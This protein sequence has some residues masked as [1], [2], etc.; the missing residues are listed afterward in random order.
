MC[1]FTLH[2]RVIIT[3]IWFS[4]TGEEKASNTKGEVWYVE[5]SVDNPH[6][7][8]FILF[9]QFSPSFVKKPPH[10]VAGPSDF[11]IVFI[12]SFTVL[13]NQVHVNDESFQIEVPV[14][15]R[16]GF[17]FNLYAACK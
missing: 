2:V 16:K 1:P 3:A 13:K 6:W 12:K 7:N 10:A 8:F 9:Q 15:I 5:S 17:K 4:V 14:I 11:W